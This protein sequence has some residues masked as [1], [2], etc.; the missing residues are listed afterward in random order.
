MKIKKQI[1]K[2]FRLFLSVI[3]LSVIF[4][5]SVKAE[6]GG[7]S[8]TAVKQYN[9]INNL[10]AEMSSNEDTYNLAAYFG[11][12]ADDNGKIWV[13]KSVSLNEMKLGDRV[14]A[15]SPS[16][17]G[18]VYNIMLS[19]LAQ[20]YETVNYPVLP[21]DVVF[22]L[23]VSGSMVFNSSG[24]TATQTDVN[25]GN[26]R[27]LQ[28]VN[29]INVSIAALMASN[30]NNRIGVVTYSGSSIDGTNDGEFNGYA[31]VMTQANRK[32]RATT[33]LTLNSYDASAV[34]ATDGKYLHVVNSFSGGSV[35]SSY[36]KTSTGLAIKNGASVAV[37]SVQ[38]V[39]GTYTQ[40]GIATGSY[41]LENSTNPTVNGK[42]ARVPVMVLFTD[43]APGYYK[44]TCTPSSVRAL[45][46]LYGNG[47]P[48]QL[49]AVGRNNAGS[50][51]IATAI[52]AKQLW[53]SRYIHD[54]L[55][56]TVGVAIASNSLSSALL[57]PKYGVNMT[58]GSGS[59]SWNYTGVNN[60]VT[61]QS[62]HNVNNN[63]GYGIASTSTNYTNLSFSNIIDNAA[64]EKSFNEILYD[65]NVKL[66]RPV[67][68]SGTG[69]TVTFTDTVGQDLT[70]MGLPNVM[71]NG[72]RFGGSSMANVTFSSNGSGGYNASV[73]SGGGNFIGYIDSGGSDLT[74]YGITWNELWGTN[75]NPPRIRTYYY[76]APT[77]TDDPNG[78]FSSSNG[79][80]KT[81][82]LVHG[83]TTYSN[84]T[85][86][87]GYTL[88]R[89]FDIDL[90][91][92]WSFNVIINEIIS[93]EGTRNLN[94]INLSVVTTWP[95]NSDTS[96]QTLNWTIPEA[97]L[98]VF[99]NNQGSYSE[100][101]PI[102]LIFAAGFTDPSST[103]SGKTYYIN[104]Y[105]GANHV[106]I[107]GTTHTC[108][109]C[110]AI[111]EPDTQNPCYYN[112]LLNADGRVAIY[113]TY[114]DLLNELTTSEKSNVTTNY[115]T[116]AQR[117]TAT[118]NYLTANHNWKYSGDYTPIALLKSDIS[119]ST[120]IDVAD[121]TNTA[122]TYYATK[123]EPLT[124]GGQK[125][126]TAYLGNNGRIVLSQIAPASV[127]LEATKATNGISL[128]NS[129]S[130]NFAAYPVSYSTDGTRTVA[131]QPIATGSNN[132][133]GAT[134]GA[135]TF[136]PNLELAAVGEYEYVIRE[137]AGTNTKF[138]YSNQVFTAIVTVSET[139]NIDLA[140]NVT[141]Y[142]GQKTH[143]TDSLTEI[144]TDNPVF[145][146]NYTPGS[147]TVPIEA[148][149]KLSGRTLSA[150]EFS[151]TLT[152][153]D[154]SGNTLTGANAYSE[155]VSNLSPVNPPTGT[156]STS[157]IPF[158]SLH[159]S[160]EGTRYFK[161]TENIPTNKLGGVTYTPIY[162][163]CRVYV[164]ANTVTGL[165]EPVTTYYKIDNNV[166]SQLSS[167]TLPDF[168]NSYAA[169]GSAALAAQTTLENRALGA[170]E[171]S[172]NIFGATYSETDILTPSDSPLSI[173]QNA[174]GTTSVGASTGV[175]S[176][177]GVAF[178]TVNYTLSDVGEHYYL[179]FEDT[180]NLPANVVAKSPTPGVFAAKVTVSD[181]GD[182][183]LSVATTYFSIAE[184]D[185]ALMLD[186]AL[187]DGQ[188]PNFTN[189]Y[190]AATVSDST[191]AAFEAT[192]ILLDK[193][194]AA[195]EFSF[196]LTEVDSSGTPLSG[197]SA[198][199]QTKQNAVGSGD[200]STSGSSGSVSFDPIALSS[201]AAGYPG[202]TPSGT[203][204]QKT[205]RYKIEETVP[206]PGDEYVSYSSDYFFAE[207]TINY[208]Y[209][210]GALSATNKKYLDKNNSQLSG[211]NLP[212]FTNNYTGQNAEVSV[213]ATKILKNKNLAAGEFSFTLTRTDASGTPLS[214]GSA[215]SQ[216]KQ[217]AVGSGQL[218]TGSVTFDPIIYQ[219]G[220]QNSS[221]YYYV[222]REVPSADAHYTSSSAVY[223]VKVDVASDLNSGK[224]SAAPTFYEGI[225]TSGTTLSSI[226]SFIFENTYTPD[227]VS[228]EIDATTTL[229]GRDLNASE[230]E[231]NA[232][233][234]TFDGTTLI[235]GDP[236][237]SDAANSA[238]INPTGTD[239]VGDVDFSKISYN[240]SDIGDH[241]YL[242]KEEGGSLDD[243]T[244]SNAVYAAKV[245]VTQNLDTGNLSAVGPIYY[246]VI[247]NGDTLYQSQTT[248]DTKNVTIPSFS[249]SGNLNIFK[250]TDDKDTTGDTTLALGSELPAGVEPNFINI[251]V[252]DTA[253]ITINTTKIL[254]GRTLNKNKFDFTLTAIDENGN[255]LG[256]TDEGYFKETITNMGSTNTSTDADGKLTSSGPVKFPI[257]YTEDYDGG[258]TYYYRISEKTGSD[259]SHYL[260][261]NQFYTV[262]VDIPADFDSKTFSINTS[263]YNSDGTPVKTSLVFKNIYSANPLP[264]WIQSGDSSKP[265]SWFSMS[266]L[267]TIA[268]VIIL[269]YHK[270][271]DF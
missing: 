103:T 124:S 196:T 163:K 200:P 32:P 94:A 6:D 190:S 218:S 1:K 147:I 179:I 186:A 101:Q 105:D 251:Y 180:S 96:I 161:I 130:F 248:F 69:S 67:Q 68:G 159:F 106:T 223:T 27:V 138:T 91:A 250:P 187:N 14:V 192:K 158:S 152:E 235:Q 232:Y 89:T 81:G 126:I 128:S 70:L 140:A 102:R 56:Y 243:M 189:T 16:T 28:A 160:T 212:T 73:G 156:T 21:V 38:V 132:P 82:T 134:P 125:N 120:G 170:S 240:L 228:A 85:F 46:T 168:A 263:F 98:P 254:T 246:N 144:T 84:T 31:T 35:S 47:S 19:A 204:Y 271:R 151:F 59:T 127:T 104:G 97:L 153:T 195:G 83:N 262:R 137:I 164:T 74:E 224:L 111:Y 43:G 146:N 258:K 8:G 64:L 122:E 26:M 197:D 44:P 86:S 178:G 112:R 247:K 50:S 203:V 242:L 174:S 12:G 264:Y 202:T 41:L 201:A 239:N 181:N 42:A 49:T 198:Y 123:F 207:V 116:D 252:D 238:E 45:G 166:E 208:D 206:V 215:Y 61:N 236:A 222:L 209:S 88:T 5:F 92:S 270:K 62:N 40:G 115:S 99:T 220:A 225:G 2:Y 210:T 255:E 149:K 173:S 95:E 22:V 266:I 139:T 257:N 188:V 58:G 63:I 23:D 93:G 66:E 77:S 256:A 205:H 133:N 37:N 57:D 249:I 76:R 107:N 129:E 108:G 221:P 214:G 194:L 165:L 52:T 269:I 109:N 253:T 211:S 231:F 53:A 15:P 167:G 234:A 182:G 213:V 259:P 261:S 11:S 176:T 117:L 65:I 141:Y 136:T 78:S 135:V 175:T 18:G 7:I 75:N 72:C 3:I 229:I 184:N 9:I 172:F 265:W 30:P 169:T 185:G 80:T 100:N 25:N 219:E 121:V 227:A 193:N 177:G 20:S 226:D 29:S 267:S 24:T 241:Y 216:T 39:G 4:I 113:S 157:S 199:S 148:T 114:A 71:Y 131:T 118:I 51:T 36:V 171:F 110:T 54:A 10:K 245:T 150:G 162:Y 17:E 217:N 90:N 55:F 230:F 143:K 119:Q 79:G 13:D 34:T 260:Y 237:T 154:A 268:L 48:E 191:A 155:T 233:N 60:A 244:Y 145:I 33:L 142:S 183:T 87:Y